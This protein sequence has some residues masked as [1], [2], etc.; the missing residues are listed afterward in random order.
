VIVAGI[1]TWLWIAAGVGALW[2]FAQPSAQTT[3]AAPSLNG[4]TP[5]GGTPPPQFQVG[6]S[7]TIAQNAAM[8]SDQGLTQNVGTFPG[9]MRTIMS[10]D[11]N[12]SWVG[13][14]MQGTGAGLVYFSTSSISAP[15]TMAAG[16]SAGHMGS[17]HGGHGPHGNRAFPWGFGGVPLD[18]DVNVYNAGC[19]CADLPRLNQYCTRVAGRGA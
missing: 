8:F 18:Y 4:N 14:A 6:Q 5:A 15:T 12:G 13:F 16:F 9:G 1:P 7:V 3:V 10:V 11:P 17:G 2:Y 19:D